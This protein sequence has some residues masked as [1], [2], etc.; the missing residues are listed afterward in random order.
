MKS[1]ALILLTAFTSSLYGQNISFSTGL[2]KTAAGTEL[3]VASG[4][5]TKNNWS[6]G[7]F[8]QTK[9]MNTQTEQIDTR[10]GS[11]WYGLYINAPLANSKKIKEMREELK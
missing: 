5:L 9:I 11:N 1:F 10:L 6:L 7:V 3:N 2:E 4:Y 8:H